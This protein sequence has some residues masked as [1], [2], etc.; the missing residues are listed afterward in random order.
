[1]KQENVFHYTVGELVE[2]LKSFPKNIPIL[3]SG[4]ENGFE[5]IQQPILQ[6]LIHK[7]DNPYYDGQF[8]SEEEGDRDI[9]KSVILRR[10]VRE[11][12]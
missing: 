7:P 5:N 2:I 4:Y 9:F 8:Q 11:I 12:D 6:Y 1:M 10:V 3:T